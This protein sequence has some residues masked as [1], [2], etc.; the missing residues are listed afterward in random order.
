M[1]ILFLVMFLFLAGC[2]SEPPV[3]IDRPVEVEVP[4]IVPPPEPFEIKEPFLPIELLEP[5]HIDE[6]SKIA[7]AYVK[8][9]IILQSYANRLQCTLDTYRTTTKK[10]CKDGK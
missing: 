9:V 8:S 7:I 6:P 3:Y 10:M 5:E 4:V 2:A 1:K